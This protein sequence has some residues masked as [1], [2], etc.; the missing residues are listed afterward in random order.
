M[1]VTEV[2]NFGCPVVGHLIKALYKPKTHFMQN[3]IFQ[4]RYTS[5]FAEILLIKLYFLLIN[6][7][8]NKIKD[9]T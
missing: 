6:L 5:I 3:A 1:L 9:S 7:W 4:N 2:V 8:L